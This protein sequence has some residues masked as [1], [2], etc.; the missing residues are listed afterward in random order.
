MPRKIKKPIE[1]NFDI[2]RSN[3]QISTAGY[4]RRNEFLYLVYEGNSIGLNVSHNKEQREEDFIGAM[5]FEA[6]IIRERF[7]NAKIN[8]NFPSYESRFNSFLDGYFGRPA[9]HASTTI[10]KPLGKRRR[11]R[12]IS[13]L[14]QINKNEMQLAIAS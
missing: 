8:I 5:M 7:P 9:I 4:I 2:Y 11:A 1:V 6:E 12:L 13:L 14:T 3:F 10:L